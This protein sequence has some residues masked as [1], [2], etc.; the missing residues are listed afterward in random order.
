MIEYNA[1]DIKEVMEITGL[2]EKKA[3]KL[4]VEIAKDVDDGTDDELCSYDIIDII[5]MEHKGKVNGIRHQEVGE[6]P[7][8]KKVRE[9]KVDTEKAKLL[10][11]L[12]SGL[13]ENDI[14][15][16]TENEVKLH[17][18]YNGSAYSVT[19]TKHR[20]PKK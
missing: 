8:T 14:T 20:P 3:E 15:V 12:A 6:K 7:K 2:D 9:R 16:T 13:E 10:E 5:K 11:M 4:F 19:L 17:F 1:D 18:S